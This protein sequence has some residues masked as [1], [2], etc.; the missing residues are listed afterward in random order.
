MNNAMKARLLAGKPA[1]GLSV[2]IPCPQIVEMAAHLG[3]HW[4]LIDCEHGAIDVQQVEILA[5]AAA[6]AGITAVAR[7]LSKD[8]G[9][10]LRVMDRGVS[11][12][13]VPHVNGAADARAAVQAVKYHPLGR[14]GLGAGTRS[15]RYGIGPSMREYVEDANRDTL[16]CVQ[17]EDPEGLE[18]LEELVAVP[19]VD[20]F[21][22]GPSDLSNALGFPGQPDAPAVREAIDAALSRITAAGRTAGMPCSTGNVE[23]VLRRGVLYTYTH[24]HRLLEPAAA[25]F[26]RRARSPAVG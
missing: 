17:V 21:F 6:A 10:I 12:V 3:F 7:P 5:M 13:Q 20:V 24:L 11:G 25:E 16:V 9:D 8:P 23:E 4:V 19:Q 1:F 22:V 18:N 15:A 26:F 14:R 2:M